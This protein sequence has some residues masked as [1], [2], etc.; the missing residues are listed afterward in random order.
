MQ[1]RC[2]RLISCWM[3]QSRDVHHESLIT[4]EYHWNLHSHKRREPAP[5]I[6]L[7]SPCVPWHRHL[8]LHIMAVY[9]QD[10]KYNETHILR[11][12]VSVSQNS[13]WMISYIAIKQQVLVLIL[14]I[15]DFCSWL[16]L[17]FALFFSLTLTWD[18]TK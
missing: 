3:T 15:W 16:G 2:S 13:I 17:G 7:P 12:T 11:C 6:V 5:Q 4:K 1:K 9:T 18:L 8:Q 10:N 14:F